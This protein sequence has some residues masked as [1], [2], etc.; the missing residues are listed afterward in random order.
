[1]Y[2][3]TCFHICMSLYGYNTC[4]CWAI[5]S[6]CPSAQQRP[7]CHPLH[8]LCNHKCNVRTPASFPFCV[9]NLD[10]SFSR[11]NYAPLPSRFKLGLDHV[12]DLSN[13][14]RET[15]RLVG[16]Q[17]AKLQSKEQTLSTAIYSSHVFWTFLWAMSKWPLYSTSNIH[18]YIHT[19]IHVSVYV[20]SH[21][22]STHVYLP[23]KHACIYRWENTEMQDTYP[24]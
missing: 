16:T 23:L 5:L 14:V 2:L 13:H 12:T 1:M 17:V 6:V 18:T 9:A 10:R 20:R 7:P 22:T 3:R 21:T 11:K 15:D 8:C 4:I 24:S 19:H